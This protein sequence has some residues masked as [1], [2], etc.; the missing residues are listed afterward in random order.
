M[1]FDELSLHDALKQALRENNF[2]DMTPIQEQAIPAG[3]SG[4]D[5][6]G[7]AQTGTGKTISFLVPVIDRLLNEK[8]EGP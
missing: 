4:K 2:T 1:K 6:T 8:L 3:L 5:I 7:L